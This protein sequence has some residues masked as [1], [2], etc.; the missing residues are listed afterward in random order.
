MKFGPST[1]L[2][3]RYLQSSR[4]A[5]GASTSV[6]I[7]SLAVGTWARCSELGK[8][9]FWW[10]E[11]YC[12]VGAATSQSLGQLKQEWMDV[13]GHPP[14]YMLLLY[15]W[16]KLVP[17]TEITARLPGCVSGMLVMLLLA[18]AP[19]RRLPRGAAFY[20]AALF[21]LGSEWIY[22]AQTV[23]QY[24]FLVACSVG[25]LLEWAEMYSDPVP[26][27]AAWL[28]LS[29]WLLA[30]AYL[31]YLGLLLAAAIF[32]LGLLRAVR[33]R[34]GVQIVLACGLVFGLAYIP[35]LLALLHMVS[36]HLG[37]WQ[38]N[39]P[40]LPLVAQYMQRAFFGRWWWLTLLVICASAM[41]G[42]RRPR[43]PRFIEDPRFQAVAWVLC[44]VVAQ[45]AL[46][47]RF[48]PF[49]QLRYLTILYAP[50]L[51][52]L[53]WVLSQLAPVETLRGTVVL[54][55]IVASGLV[56]YSDYRMT[57]KQD[58]RASA[59][60]VIGE[61]SARDV[62]YVLGADPAIPALTYLERK[63][64]DE[65]FY[66]RD[67]AFYAYYF[68]RLAAP[69]LASA[70]RHLSMQQDEARSTLAT[71]RARKIFVLA[72]HHLAL[73]DSTLAGLEADGFR[74]DDA[75]LFSTHLYRLQR[76]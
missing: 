10:D 34:T 13:D 70:L 58:W 29:A 48:N 74:V 52:V 63:Q 17:T 31:H 76:R 51:L 65:F 33:S 45:F 38:S 73:H 43:S 22:Y 6:L 54:V 72:P 50:A 55:A 23:R 8:R 12:V 35:P 27:R 67:L 7:A 15:T 11:L 26:K 28:R 30:A 9:G 61:Y 24:S 56:S 32:G 2:P 16:F 25:A 53:A 5:L 41:P 59:A 71:T 60:L 4:S 66:C 68:R 40:L 49:L 36:L 69:H 64:I 42:F 21:A 57:Q 37:H 1:A 39:E 75:R 62:I 18:L 44:L 20:A 14:G 19:G 47:T 46:V 3:L